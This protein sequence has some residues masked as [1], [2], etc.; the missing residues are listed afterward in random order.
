MRRIRNLRGQHFLTATKHYRLFE[1]QTS[2]LI[3]HSDT[4]A[5]IC[6]QTPSQHI[7]L[8][9]E[10]NHSEDSSSVVEHEELASHHRLVNI[11]LPPPSKLQHKRIAVSDEV[12]AP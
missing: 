5:M 3:L 1:K 11:P 12:S 8:G 6:F 2:N 9:T 10:E 4:A 7:L